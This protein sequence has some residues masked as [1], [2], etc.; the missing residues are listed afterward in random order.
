M[1]RSISKS[2]TGYIQNSHSATN[3]VL[4]Q[5]QGFEDLVQKFVQGLERGPAGRVEKVETKDIEEV[6]GEQGFQQR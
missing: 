1:A 6:S 4:G 3:Q 5:V 2:L